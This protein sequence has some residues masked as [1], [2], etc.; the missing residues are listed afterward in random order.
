MP[1]P[2][3][4]IKAFLSQPAEQVVGDDDEVLVQAEPMLHRSFGQRLNH[5][6]F[7]KKPSGYSSIS[8][9]N[10]DRTR[11]RLFFFNGNGRGR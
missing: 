2:D 6:L 4:P 11:T 5:F 1:E 9:R 3:D 10:A 8:P 7:E